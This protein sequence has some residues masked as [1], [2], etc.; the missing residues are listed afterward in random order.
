VNV[1]KDRLLAF[2][3]D[4]IEE[5]SIEKSAS[6]EPDVFLV[7]LFVKGAL[8]SRR[9]EVLAET[10]S[11]ISVTRC[12]SIARWLRNAFEENEEIRNLVG[13]DY[14]LMVSSPGIGEPIQHAR[15]YIRHKGHLLRVRFTDA[16][17]AEHEVSGRLVE[18]EVVETTSPFI[19]L[20]PEKVSKGRKRERLEPVRLELNR[21]KSAVVEV[22][23]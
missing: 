9:V 10:D 15:Q 22:E 16:G 21:I 20:E 1:T 14:G 18:V 23:F 7:A 5:Y 11:G 13:E 17:D 3:E 8:P 19:V 12:M 2:I 6:G 4:S